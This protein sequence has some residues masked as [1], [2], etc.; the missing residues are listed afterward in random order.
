M[1]RVR[2]FTPCNKYY[3]T[4]SN[5]KNQERKSIVAIVYTSLF[6]TFTI[7]WVV[8]PVAFQI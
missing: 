6:T 7:A 8:G 3:L 1:T 4:M 5:S 2:M